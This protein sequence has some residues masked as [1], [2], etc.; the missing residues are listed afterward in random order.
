[1]SISTY[2]EIFKEKLYIIFGYLFFF[3]E[4]VSRDFLL[5]KN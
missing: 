2:S 1:M 4:F 3:Y 5:A